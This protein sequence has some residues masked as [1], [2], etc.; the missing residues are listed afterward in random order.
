MKVVGL[1]EI[2]ENLEKQYPNDVMDI[3]TESELI[4]RKAQLEVIEYIKKINE[5]G[6]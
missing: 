2:I 5:K 1:K 4:A 3:K 6:M